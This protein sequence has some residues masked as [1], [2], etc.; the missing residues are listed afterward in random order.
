MKSLRR[1]SLERRPDRFVGR[2][3]VPQDRSYDP[4]D[5]H[6]ATCSVHRCDAN[7]EGTRFL[8]LHKLVGTAFQSGTFAGA[9]SFRTATP[10]FCARAA[11]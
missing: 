11:S 3:A 6:T 5:P 8:R 9:D 7:L 10:G 2:N 1:P 4:E